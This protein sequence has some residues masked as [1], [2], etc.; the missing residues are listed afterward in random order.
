[1]FKCFV[2]NSTN[3]TFPTRERE[4][5]EPLNAKQLNFE[6]Q[7]IEPL[8]A[9]HLNPERQAFEPLNAKHLNF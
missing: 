4:A 3:P 8:N 7:A 6:R 5:F 9:K 1:V 2:F